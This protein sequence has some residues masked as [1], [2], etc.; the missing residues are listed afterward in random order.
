MRPNV[1]AWPR[2]RGIRGDDEVRSECQ[3]L[4]FSTRRHRRQL[5]GR[6]PGEGRRVHAVEIPPLRGGF[7]GTPPTSGLGARLF[8]RWRTIE[9]KGG[10]RAADGGEVKGTPGSAAVA[11]TVPRR[12]G[13]CSATR[14]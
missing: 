3:P 5:R 7:D 1:A 4:R 9:G 13:T 10:L 11:A 6:G 2:W 8:G 12:A 14:T